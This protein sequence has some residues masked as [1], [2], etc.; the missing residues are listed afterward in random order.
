M[1]FKRF[2]PLLW[3]ENDSELIRGLAFLGEDSK[4]FQNAPE[5]CQRKARELVAS[6]WKPSGGLSSDALSKP[7]KIEEMPY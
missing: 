3:D 6:G 7:I 5:V 4:I 1:G 2:S